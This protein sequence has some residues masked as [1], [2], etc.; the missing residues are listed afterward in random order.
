MASITTTDVRTY[1][2]HRQ[3]PADG[4]GT[5]G[6]ANAT[7][8]R[9]LAVLKRAFRLAH[10]AGTVMHVPHIPM[11]RENNVRSG[12]FERDE[13]E[14]V[15]GQLLRP[16]QAVATFGYLTGWRVPSEVLTLT[17]AQ[18]DRRQ[19]TIRLEPG[20]TKNSEGRTLPYDLLPELAGSIDTTS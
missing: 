18:V 1:I 19:Q 12:F 2:S 6:A 5:I 16:L 17:W 4:D 20:A 15:R 8:N 13:F 11:L 9:E 10:Q 7:I 3:A 14:A